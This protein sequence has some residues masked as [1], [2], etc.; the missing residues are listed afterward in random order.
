MPNHNLSGWKKQQPDQRDWKFAARPQ[1]MAALPPSVDL[2]AGVGPV[3]DQGQL[4]SCGPNAEDTLLMYDQ[5]AEGI[6]V[7]SQSRLFLYYTT[8]QVMGTT[9]YDSGVDNRSMLKACA[10]YGF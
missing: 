6:P 5:R 3:L 2:T 1:V 7:S 8:R 4:G 9:S 10:Q